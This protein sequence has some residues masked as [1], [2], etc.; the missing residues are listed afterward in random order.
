MNSLVQVHVAKSISL[1][2]P[3]M[4]ALLACVMMTPRLRC[5]SLAVERASLAAMEPPLALL[6]TTPAMAPTALR[7]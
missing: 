1:A 6:P 3:A 2:A 7:R 5:A 4:C